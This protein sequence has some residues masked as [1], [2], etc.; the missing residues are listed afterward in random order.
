M[1]T[2]IVLFRKI[3]DSLQE[4]LV[5]RCV[6]QRKAKPLPLDSVLL[7]L[8]ELSHLSLILKPL[9]SHSKKNSYEGKKNR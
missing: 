5:D 4:V 7:H 1:L 3:F 6:F 2:W 8:G 9:V